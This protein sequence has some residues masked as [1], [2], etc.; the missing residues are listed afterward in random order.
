MK[1]IAGIAFAALT[2]VACGPPAPSGPPPEYPGGLLAPSTLR[3]PPALGDA[4][5]LEQRV[6]IESPEGSWEFRAVLQKRGDTLILVGLGPHGGRG[7]VLQQ[8]GDPDRGGTVE[9]ES[10]LPQ[11]LPFPPRFMLQDVQRVW[12]RGL[13]G[14]LPDGEH[15]DTID[16]DEITERWEGGRLLERTFRRVDGVPEG[17]L[18]ATYEGGLGGDAPPPSVRFE[19]GWFGYT[20]ILTTLSHQRIDETAGGEAEESSEEVDADAD[21]EEQGAE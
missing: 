3:S 2:L 5:A 4:F 18:H 13:A 10:H 20:L 21:G 15:V 8:N 6:R 9:L 14:P 16:G 11:E 17:T 19:N 1:R 12:F 7:F